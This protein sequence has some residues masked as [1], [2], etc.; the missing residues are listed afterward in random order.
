MHLVAN[1]VEKLEQM[2]PFTAYLPV[3]TLRD[4]EILGLVSYAQLL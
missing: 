2:P 1:R 4:L 3:D